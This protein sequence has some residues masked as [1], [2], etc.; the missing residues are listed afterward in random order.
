MAIASAGHQKSKFRP[1][2]RPQ[3]VAVSGLRDAGAN[4]K[5]ARMVGERWAASR[6]LMRFVLTI[7]PIRMAFSLCVLL[8]PN[9]RK[10]TWQKS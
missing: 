7:R 5:T 8:A 1:S 3:Q 10:L 9:R 2:L 6:Y 4:P